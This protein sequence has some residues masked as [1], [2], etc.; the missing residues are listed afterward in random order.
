M[1]SNLYCFQI[2]RDPTNIDHKPCVVKLQ[3]KSVILQRRKSWNGF[4]YHLHMSVR[5][6]KSSTLLTTE[7]D[8]WL[9][10]TCRIRN[11]STQQC[12][13][14]DSFRRTKGRKNEITPITINM[15]NGKCVIKISFLINNSYVLLICCRF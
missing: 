15:P 6:S 2:H 1:N 5:P 3:F 4:E 14:C 7:N 8:S 11:C 12:Q 13:N 9:C 10:N